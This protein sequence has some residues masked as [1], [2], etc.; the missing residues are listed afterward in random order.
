MSLAT[1]DG[2]TYNLVDY[3]TYRCED[4]TV[5]PALDD[6]S[7]KIMDLKNEDCLG[8]KTAISHFG[9]LLA[10]T[11][12]A[13]AKGDTKIQIA[14]APKSKVDAPSLALEALIAHINPPETIY[15]SDF[16]VRITDKPSAHNEGG[17]R[18]ID[19]QLT[20]ISSNS[21]ID[22][23]T[24]VLLLDDVTTTGNTLDA[25]EQIL[26]TAGATTVVKLVVG[27]TV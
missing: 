26:R 22:P 7:R 8:H 14:I 17:T 24:P 15:N 18:D 1:L 2:N 13:L 9:A 27:K 6:N 11:V 3:H 4:G 20:T 5:N 25:C 23:D 12:K 21:E 19:I 16:L 10:S